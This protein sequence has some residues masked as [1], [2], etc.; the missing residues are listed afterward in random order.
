[1]VRAEQPKDATW[2]PIGPGVLRRRLPG[3]E[4]NVAVVT[5]RDGILLV[6][7]GS[8]EREAA[9][10]LSSLA[11]ELPA[12]GLPDRI[13]AVVNT[14]GHFDHC[15]GND[16]VLRVFPDAEVWGHAALPAY[17]ERYADAGRA[18]G[19][20]HG[21][22]VDLMNAARIVPPTRL[23]PTGDAVT[24]DLGG[25]E[26][27]LYAPGRGHTDNDLVVHVPDCGVLIAGDM[28]EESGPPLFGSDAFAAEWSDSL[29]RVR[30]L[31]ASVWLPGHGAVVDEDF[32][33][34]QNH[35]LADVAAGRVVPD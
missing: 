13:V 18:S 20:E 5:G 22:D 34:R 24:V 19:I 6:D 2:E 29:G 7:T 30:A 8:H 11:R 10:L 21:F 16:Y 32:V 33:V 17:L 4:L 14:H 12:H 15:Y 25:R 31:D 9:E 35:W 1:M 3:L 27:V 28:V 23:V 26:V